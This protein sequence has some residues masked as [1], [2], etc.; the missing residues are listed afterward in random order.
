ME[1][2][3]G[4]KQVEAEIMTLGDFILNF[5]R[6]PFSGDSDKHDA[7][8]PGYHVRYVNPD[9][10]HYDSWSP[11]DVFKKSYSVAETFVDRMEIEKDEY[12]RKN[13]KLKSFLGSEK[14]SEI[15]NRIPALANLM[16]EQSVIFD[17]LV[18]ILEG[19]LSVEYMN[20][21][22]CATEELSFGS[23][24]VAL[25][26]GLAIR[27]SGWNGKGLFVVKQIPAHITGDIIPNMQSLP[28]SAKD[29]LM[30]RENPHIDYTNQ[31]LIVNPDGRADSWIPSSSDVFAHD[32]EIVLDK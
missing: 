29:I 21:I 23:A 18:N 1:K 17:R 24:V 6:N 20:G 25:E 10:S 30:K 12:L 27:R 7:D 3:I 8:E 22:E 28:Q 32:W 2:Y 31:M 9:G 4:T 11:R 26:N 19:R 5:N 16:K 14:F 15:V 13:E